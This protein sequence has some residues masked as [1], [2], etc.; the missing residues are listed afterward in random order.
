MVLPPLPRACPPTSGS[1]HWPP[2][3]CPGAREGHEG[4]ELHCC[5]P[6]LTPRTWHR[7]VRE[8]HGIAVRGPEELPFPSSWPGSH[9]SAV[10]WPET[11]HVA[12]PVPGPLARSE[13]STPR[14]ARVPHPPVAGTTRWTVDWREILPRRPGP[15]T[16]FSP[17]TSAYS[18]F[19]SFSIYEIFEDVDSSGWAWPEYPAAKCPVRWVRDEV[20][21]GATM[22]GDLGAHCL[23]PLPCLHLLCFISLPPP[24]VFLL[25][26]PSVRSTEGLLGPRAETVNNPTHCSIRPKTRG[27]GSRGPALRIPARPRLPCR[28]V[29]GVHC[30]R[31]PRAGV[32]VHA[33][34]H[35]PLVYLLGQFSGRWS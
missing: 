11:L 32:V 14:Q 21:S 34:E 27:Q 24:C 1:P 9:L 3:P 22:D 30:A 17:V 4:P 19:L 13:G 28:F 18:G 29:Q 35:G 31:A 12:R 23:L 8:T 10:D 20:C 16:S 7:S 2:A 26:R 25:S 5:L 6:P 33:V 15:V